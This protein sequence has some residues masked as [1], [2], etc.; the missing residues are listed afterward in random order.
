MELAARTRSAVLPRAEFLPPPSGLFF[1][2]Q[3]RGRALTGVAAATVAL[4]LAGCSRPEPPPEPVRSVK[5]LTVGV[6]ALQ[7]Q[8]EYAGEVRA[9]VE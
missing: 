4:C 5:L 3:G 2:L 8:L 7:L 1:R 9:R 6:N